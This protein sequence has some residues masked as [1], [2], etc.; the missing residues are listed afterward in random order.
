[1]AILPRSRDIA[2]HLKITRTCV[3]N[4]NFVSTYLYNYLS[5]SDPL[6]GDAPLSTY[7]SDLRR[8]L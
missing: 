8:V 6:G 2:G 5:A 1:M 4:T 3:H 7:L